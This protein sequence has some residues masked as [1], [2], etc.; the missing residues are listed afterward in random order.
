MTCLACLVKGIVEAVF[1]LV[2]QH[3]RET[4]GGI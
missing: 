3:F 2:G 1:K 4:S